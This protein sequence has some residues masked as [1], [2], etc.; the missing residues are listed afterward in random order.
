MKDL[1]PGP[2]SSND[3]ESNAT[4]LSL[5]IFNKMQYLQLSGDRM[6]HFLRNGIP[7]KMLIEQ[8]SK[9][10]G[11]LTITDLLDALQ[12]LRTTGQSDNYDDLSLRRK[13]L[14]PERT[15]LQK[16]NKAYRHILESI[17]RE[18]KKKSK[19]YRAWAEAIRIL[20]ERVDNK[21]YD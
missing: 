21:Q 11:H 10:L 1:V 15:D 4:N 12:Y 20:L 17:M 19:G 2:A 7:V 13:L 6:E 5:D 16:E 8:E 18:F 3:D 14:N 9:G